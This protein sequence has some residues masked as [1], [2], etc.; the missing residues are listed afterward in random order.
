MTGKP[1]TRLADIGSGFGCY[2][3]PT[4]SI[5]ASPNVNIDG[6]VAM[7][8][9]DAYGTLPPGERRVVSSAPAPPVPD[10]AAPSPRR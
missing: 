3:P 2:F 8:Q 9:D 6:I 1:S 7:R 5:S 10:P 4:P